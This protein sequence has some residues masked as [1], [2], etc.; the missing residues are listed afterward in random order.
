MGSRFSFCTCK[1][2]ALKVFPSHALQQRISAGERD[3]SAG[4]AGKRYVRIC[5]VSAST[6]AKLP[7]PA[8]AALGALCA[9]VSASLLLM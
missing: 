3:T 8:S 6:W 7:A 2:C 5:Y 4:S 1:H 9:Y